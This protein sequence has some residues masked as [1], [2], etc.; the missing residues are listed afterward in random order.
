MQRV[1]AQGGMYQQLIAWQQ[2]ALSMA[3]KYEP[4]MAEGLAQSIMGGMGAAMPAKQPGAEKDI[5]GITVED[6][7][8]HAV[9]RRAREQSRE[10]SQA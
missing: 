9:V 7:Q 4:Q 1:A 6:T 8:E 2:M 10:A 5:E 3:Q